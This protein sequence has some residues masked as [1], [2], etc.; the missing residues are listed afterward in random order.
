MR[1]SI[2]RQAVKHPWLTTGAMAGGAM[3][4]AAIVVL[5]GVVPIRASSGHWAITAAFLDF[6]KTRSVWTSSWGIR[7]PALD[8]EALSVKG[9]GH[10]E[11]ACLPCH[12][13]PGRSIPPIMTAMT[14]PPPELDRRRLARWSP[15]EL[16]SIVKHGIKFTGMPA[17]PTQQR[18]DEI[19]AMVAFLRRVPRLDVDGY[20]RL[21]YGDAPHDARAVASD[22]IPATVRDTCSRCHGPAG[23]GRGAGA[24]PSIAGQRSAYVYA[25][26]LA[27]RE[28]RRFSAIMSEVADRL[29][30]DAM[31]EVAAY[32]EQLPAREPGQPR[33]EVAVGRGRTIATHGIPSRDIPACAEC[34]GPTAVPKNPAYPT[35][36]SQHATYLRGQLMLLQERRRGGTPNVNLMH[37]FVNRLG[38]SEILDAAEYYA[39]AA[40]S[41]RN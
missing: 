10:Y 37:A 25:S 29:D 16:F 35:L 28:R 34:H 6:A 3:L 1:A 39:A 24:I 22:A 20:R 14:P 4:I 12:G 38:E 17:W 31:R 41:G 36:T 19:W 7:A 9:A 26:L 5:S 18:D 15:E 33:D 30:D 21:V 2:V 32:Y 40:I 13:G 27:F 8:V 11:T 23:T